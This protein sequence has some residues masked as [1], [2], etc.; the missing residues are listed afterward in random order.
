[1]TEKQ[2][3]ELLALDIIADIRYELEINVA[4]LDGIQSRINESGIKHIVAAFVKNQK[5]WASRFDVGLQKIGLKERMHQDLTSVEL[6]YY[7]EIM[8]AA[9]RG[10]CMKSLAKLAKA[11]AENEAL[12]DKIDALLH[13]L[14]EKEKVF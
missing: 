10:V 13:I 2:Q 12:D 7:A 9:R 8:Q 5:Q 6:G 11:A 1:M 3:R 14:D 4:V